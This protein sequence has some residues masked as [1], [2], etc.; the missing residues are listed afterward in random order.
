M[1][2]LKIINEKKEQIALGKKKWTRTSFD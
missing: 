2:H 1:S